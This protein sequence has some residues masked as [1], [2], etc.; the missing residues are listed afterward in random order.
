MTSTVDQRSRL[1]A[2]SNPFASDLALAHSS[3]CMFDGKKLM[4]AH[5]DGDRGSVT[6]DVDFVHDSLRSL[7]L[8]PRF[9]CVGAKSAFREGAYR[10][11]LYDEMASGEATAGLAHDLFR[12]AREQP[13]MDSEFTTCVASFKGPVAMDE[14]AFERRLW[15]QLQHLHDLDRRLHAWDPSVSCDPADADFSFSF[16]GR[17]FF[18]VGLHPASSRWTRRFAWPT[19]VFNVHEQFERLRE[20]G[21]FV[22]LQ[23]SIRSRDR[24]LQGSANPSLGTFGELSEAR[25][26]SGRASDADWSCPFHVGAS[27]GRDGGMAAGGAERERNAHPS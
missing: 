11:G 26:Y 19:L 7:V 12:F 13:L 15:I 14:A 4:R 16:A 17:A 18:V 25:Q 3:Y 27:R 21:R 20:Q 24:A 1:Q 9:V 22:G 8:N 6:A 23:R 5:D 2:P 10:F